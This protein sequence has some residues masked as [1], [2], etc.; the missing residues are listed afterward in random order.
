MRE[1]RHVERARRRE[2]THS[3]ARHP[4]RSTPC[5]PSRQL[6]AAARC[7][8]SAR[9]A[10]SCLP[11]VRAASLYCVCLSLCLS[12]KDA[13]NDRAF[14]SPRENSEDGIGALNKYPLPKTSVAAEQSAFLIRGWIFKENLRFCRAPLETTRSDRVSRI[15]SNAA[16]VLTTERAS[17]VEEDVSLRFPKLLRYDV[18]TRALSRLLATASDS[19]SLRQ[20]HTTRHPA[21]TTYTFGLWYPR[22]S[23]SSWYRDATETFS[24]TVAGAKRCFATTAPLVGMSHACSFVSILARRGS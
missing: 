11:E 1:A 24:S 2:A 17:R 13:V 23:K 16:R 19:V 20:Q 6:I 14:S 7:L 18:A 4:P 12:R 10:A 5:A 8:R 3:L 9:R 21:V 22:H 15:K